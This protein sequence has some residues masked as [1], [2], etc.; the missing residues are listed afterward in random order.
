MV[1]DGT[2]AF[3]GNDNNILDTGS[4]GFL[5]DVLNSWLVDDR[6]HFLRHCFRRGKEARS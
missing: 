1:L 5:Y 2:F 3:T 6:Q 4:D